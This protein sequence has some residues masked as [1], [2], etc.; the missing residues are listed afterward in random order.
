MLEIPTARGM[1]ILA[2]DEYENVL[3]RYS[4]FV[5]KTM[6]GRFY[7][8]ARIP[9]LGRGAPR[10]AMHRLIMDPPRGMVV[11]HINNNG[12]DNRRANLVVVT[13]GRNI[14]EARRDHGRHG[15]HQ[16]GRRYRAQIRLGKRR[17]SL[18]MF[19][20]E[21]EALAAVLVARIE[22]GIYP[23]LPQQVT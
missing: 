13:T 7:A 4:W 15:V 21:E 17:L 9:G 20:T 10:I 8:Q 16:I 6:A 23:P 11:H 19:S 5:V 18:G 1:T 14:A 3:A 2:D 12:L 22:H